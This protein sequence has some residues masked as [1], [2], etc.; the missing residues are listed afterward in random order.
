MGEFKQLMGEQN[1]PQCSSPTCRATDSSWTRRSKDPTASRSWGG[2]PPEPS[3]RRWCWAGEV[4]PVTDGWCCLPPWARQTQEA[5][6][7]HTEMRMMR[8]TT[9]ML[10]AQGPE[11]AD[12]SADMAGH[13]AKLERTLNSAKIQEYRTTLQACSRKCVRFLRDA[14][15]TAAADSLN[16]LLVEYQQPPP[17]FETVLRDIDSLF[18]LR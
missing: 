8:T 9:P 15:E 13:L 4:C 2:R 11:W 10:Q 7:G 16:F 18:K 17:P 3:R 6:W 5:A 1:H 12:N 14:G